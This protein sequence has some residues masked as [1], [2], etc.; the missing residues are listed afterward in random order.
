M[1]TEIHTI[2]LGMCNCYLVREEGLIL[3]D[4]GF[5]NHGSRFLKELERLAIKPADISLIVL[6]H[7]HYDHIGSVN[8]IKRL[9]GAKVAINQ[10][11]KDWVE[12]ALKPLPKA[13]GLPGKIWDIPIKISVS[14]MRFPGTVVDL[15]LNDN[16]FSLEAYGIHGKVISTPGHSSGSMSVVLD[17]GDAFVG[18][19]A[20]NGLPMRIGPGIPIFAED[21]VAVKESWRTLLAA[22]AK[23]IH[24]AHWKP[25]KAE[26]LHKLL[27]AG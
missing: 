2:R 1:K 7:G 13:V 22:G 12:Q 14:R 9:T 8:E 5:P 17:T 24:P 15:V 25:F 23:I 26:V 16:G 20:M 10:R 21:I 18:D 19:A 6:T 27:R 4:A 3:V 11:E